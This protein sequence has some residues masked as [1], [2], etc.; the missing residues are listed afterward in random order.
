MSFSDEMSNEILSSSE[1][2]ANLENIH[3][4]PISNDSKSYSRCRTKLC[5]FIYFAITTAIK[6]YN[7]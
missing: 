7:T 5:Y 1:R 6:T 4:K 3:Y 2:S